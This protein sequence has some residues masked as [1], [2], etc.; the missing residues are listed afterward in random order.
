MKLIFFQKEISF[1]RRFLQENPDGIAF[2]FAPGLSS[3]RFLPETIS[4]SAVYIEESILDEFKMEYAS[5]IGK[6]RVE[7]F[8][9]TKETDFSSGKKPICFFAASD[10]IVRSLKTILDHFQPHEYKLFC[11]GNEHAPEA[12]TQLGLGATVVSKSIDEPEQYSLLVLANDWGLMEQKLIYDF[13]AKGINSVC[14][15]ESS[16][17]FNVKTNRMGHC[18]F[19]IFQGV[20]TLA[21]LNLKQR[22]CAVIGNPRFEELRPSPMP[23]KNKALVNVN[24]TYG[25]FENIR[26]QW[27]ADIVSV[28]NELQVEFL[29]SQHPRDRGHFENLP[30][31]KSNAMKVHDALRDCSVLISRFSAL[32]TE[33]ICLGRP[34]IYYNPHREQPGY[35]FDSD[36]E[37]LFMAYNKDELRNH[38]QVLLHRGRSGTSSGFLPRHLGNTS[39]GLASHYIALAL[40]DISGFPLLRKKISLLERGRLAIRILKRKIWG[41]VW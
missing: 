6:Y 10:T 11:R 15:Q 3:Y 27:V 39:E 21:N 37:M 33:S 7:R 14:I 8:P 17:D 18:S 31:L 13:A 28:C 38:L 19:P 23:L 29:L 12:A 25:L 20:A 16:I 2:W 5:W 32:I 40:K 9:S 1:V 34:A 24:F 30:V 35:A 41:Q 26:D 36:N 4:I 22:I